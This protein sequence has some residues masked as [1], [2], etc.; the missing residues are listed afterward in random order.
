MVKAAMPWPS[1]VGGKACGIVVFGD[2]V[3]LFLG[4]LDFRR[5]F[6]DEFFKFFGA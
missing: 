1:P 3:G 5:D 4:V 6:I 2:M